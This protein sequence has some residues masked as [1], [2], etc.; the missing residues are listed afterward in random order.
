[1]Y[2]LRQVEEIDYIIVGEGEHS[3]KELLN[4][5]NGNESLEDVPGISLCDKKTNLK[6]YIQFQ[7]N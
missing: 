7:K 1:M 6:F 5:L 4:Y 2:W 3:F